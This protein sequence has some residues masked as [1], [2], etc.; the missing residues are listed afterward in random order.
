MA[1]VAPGPGGRLAWTDGHRGQFLLRDAGGTVR[2]VG[3]SGSGP[4]EF[5]TVGEMEWSGDSL[6]VSDGRLPRVQFFNDTGR[7]LH[8][9]TMPLPASWGPRP[10]TRMVGLRPRALGLD[11]PWTVVGSRENA[12]SVDTVATFPLVPAERFL[13]PA[14]NR[15][16]PNPQPL[17]PETAVGFS[18][19]HGRFCGA[20]PAGANAV[21]IRCVND[22]GQ[23]LVNR[24]VTLP[25]RPVTDAIYDDVVARFARGP[26]RSVDDIRNRIKRPRDLP[27][28][29]GL[30]VDNA[31]TIWLRRSHSSEETARWLR[32][33]ASGAARDTVLLPTRHRIIRVHADTAWVAMPDAD[34]LE[35][36]SVCAVRPA[37]SGPDGQA[38]R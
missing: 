13:L 8:V 15:A 17:H 22:Q 14:G 4:G 24:R 29:F 33:Q 32:L 1:H 21:R 12:P 26:G 7:L 19:D 2:V 35:S 28:V 37:S 36:L 34:G 10:G 18:A 38:A 25:P 23:E 30:M 9:S 5:Q 16:V 6:W 11:L 31:G 20:T 27:P 3:R